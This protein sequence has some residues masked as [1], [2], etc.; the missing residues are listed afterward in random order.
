MSWQIDE[1]VFENHLPWKAV[2]S[3]THAKQ[4]TNKFF[5]ILH[6]L[7]TTGNSSFSID[8]G[9]EEKTTL[10]HT[11]YPSTRNYFSTTFES[12]CSLSVFTSTASIVVYTL[13][14]KVYTMSSCLMKWKKEQ[15]WR[16]R[17]YIHIS[18]NNVYVYESS[19][20]NE[21]TRGTLYTY[22]NRSCSIYYLS[23]WMTK[24]HEFMVIE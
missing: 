19:I 18:M 12:A 5:H 7:T 11:L 17:R 16:R 10:S 4:I 15:W 2:K 13:V 6:R 24:D 23:I 1:C 21:M 20:E 9:L 14:Q 22:I 3:K 8:F